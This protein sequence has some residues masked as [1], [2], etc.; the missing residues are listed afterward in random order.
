MTTPEMF[1]DPTSMALVL[2]V[3]LVLLLWSKKPGINV[4]QAT[5]G[6]TIHHDARTT[7]TVTV[8]RRE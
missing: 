3:G 1:S 8:E 5:H 2:V 6:G 4:Q 7:I